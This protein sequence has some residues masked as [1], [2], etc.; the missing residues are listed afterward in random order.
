MNGNGR[1]APTFNSARQHAVPAAAAT[2]VAA[3][4]AGRWRPSPFLVAAVLLHVVGVLLLVGGIVDWRWVVAGLAGIHLTIGVAG[5]LPRCT[6]LGPCLTRLP[7]AG[8]A[9]REVAITIDDGPDPAVTPAVL[10]LLDRC[11]AKATFFCP[12]VQVERH[13]GLCREIRA[14]GHDLANHTFDHAWLFALRGPARLAREIDR[15]QATLRTVA[16]V[17]PRFFRPTAGLRNVFLYPVLARRGLTLAA[18]TRRGLDTREGDP[19]VV[20]A[21]LTRNLAAGDILL[22]HDGNAAR[23]A[24]GV[25]VILDVLPRLLEALRQ[26]ELRAV[27]LGEGSS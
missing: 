8:A 5:L 26:R 12:A 25:P 23:T 20:L 1:A 13:P 2:T 19:A 11:G 21:R 6:L 3:P 27:G 18:W 9:R 4:P 22:L 14:R 15:A 24:A 10:D 7:A 16:G 17:E